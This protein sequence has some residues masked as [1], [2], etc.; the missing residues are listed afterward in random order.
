MQ[1]DE[2]VRRTI[3]EDQRQQL[4][5]S[6]ST[7]LTTSPTTSTHQQY[8]TDCFRSV[9]YLP[10]NTNPPTADA[11][12][13]FSRRLREKYR[14]FPL[15]SFYYNQSALYDYRI[16]QQMLNNEIS[17][18]HSTQ[19]LAIKKMLL[20]FLLQA[21]GDRSDMAHSVEGRVPFLDHH[22]VDYVNHL[23]TRM[24]LKFV[25]GQ[26]L[27]KYV[28]KQAARPY[29]TDEVYRREKHPFLAPPTCL[30]RNSKIYQYI[31][32]T[33]HSQEMKDLAFIFDLDAVQ[34]SSNRLHRQQEQGNQALSRREA[35]LLESYYLTL[36]SYV[37]LKKRFNVKQDG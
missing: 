33:L 26:L 4:L 34:D 12:R 27:E 30:D 24:K 25:Q 7:T 6:L 9:G 23:P 14:D 32:E 22:L 11:Q 21:L 8:E 28:L 5:Q 15:C 3:D 16:R 20:N 29:I 19:Y 13:I 17:R 1:H 35:V 31:Q 2:T 36:C 10:L 18:V 37:T